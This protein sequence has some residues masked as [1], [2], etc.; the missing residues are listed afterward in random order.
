MEKGLLKKSNST[1]E[2][3]HDMKELI[4]TLVWG[5]GIQ[6][7]I[8]KQVSRKTGLRE[9]LVS[10]LNVEFEEI[11]QQETF[12]MF[13]DFNDCIIENFS[14]IMMFMPRQIKRVHNYKNDNGMDVIN[15]EFTSG[16]VISIEA[17]NI[18]YEE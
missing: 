1:L 15:L 12:V 8:I 9:F 11:S 16:D 7:F 4:E 14:P 5:K 18:P 13:S 17:T 6:T 2:R 3:L 10:V